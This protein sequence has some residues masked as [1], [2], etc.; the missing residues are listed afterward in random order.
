M[1][2]EA[3]LTVDIQRLNAIAQDF[4]NITKIMIVFY[5]DEKNVICRCPEIMNKCCSELRKISDCYDKCIESDNNGFAHC[6]KTKQIYIYECYMGL[7][8]AISPVCENGVIIGYIMFGQ[9]C[10]SDNKDEIYRKTDEV[11]RLY[12]D[13]YDINPCN[14]SEGINEIKTENMGNIISLVKI[15]EMCACYLWLNRIINIK[16]DSLLI[17]LDDYISQRTLD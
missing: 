16:R 10:Q 2:E 17:H 12:K 4:Y 6:D 1:R 9:I 3:M 14:I 5:D 11:V 8:E 13:K 15:L 7:T